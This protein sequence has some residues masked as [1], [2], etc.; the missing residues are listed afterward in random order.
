MLSFS[1]GRKRIWK[2]HVLQNNTTGP[3]LGS[4][5]P[6][7]QTLSRKSKSHKIQAAIWRNS[8]QAC[9]PVINLLDFG[10]VKDPRSP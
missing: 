9:P 10:W 5:P 1:E 6:K 4:L 3:K 8:L 2:N 7:D